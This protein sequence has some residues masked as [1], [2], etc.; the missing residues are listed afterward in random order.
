LPS[1]K[2]GQSTEQPQSTAFWAL[3]EAFWALTGLAG[4]YSGP[5]HRPWQTDD[6]YNISKYIDVEGKDWSGS[7]ATAILEPCRFPAD[8]EPG[9][10]PGV[11]GGG[12]PSWQPGTDW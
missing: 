4:R 1:K 7:S 12:I 2:K 9:H 11:G 6:I 5:F 8:V 3:K 10:I